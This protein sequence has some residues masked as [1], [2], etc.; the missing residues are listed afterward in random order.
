MNLIHSAERFTDTT[1]YG[2]IQF[3]SKQY[4]FGYEN[5]LVKNRQFE[6]I[7]EFEN[8]DQYKTDRMSVKR[9][10]IIS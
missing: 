1:W 6:D 3:I 2:N 8:I 4:I 7:S 10:D 9:P 5:S